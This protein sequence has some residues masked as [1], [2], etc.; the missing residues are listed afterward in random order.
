MFWGPPRAGEA[1]DLFRRGQ[2]ALA[3]DDPRE[4]IECFTRAIRLR[5]DA[6]VVY[7]YRAYAHGRLGDRISALNDLDAAI[8]L[9]PNDAQ[10]YADRAAELF[11]QQ[12]YD[13]AISDCDRALELDP[14]RV[15][16]YALRARCHAASG[17]SSRALADFAEAIA[18]DPDNAA[19]YRL[20][21]AELYGECEDYAAAMAD[22]DAALRQNPQLAAAYKLRGR[23]RQI[24]QQ[25]ADSAADF[26]AALNLQP[27]DPFALL[28]RA[29]A[30]LFLHQSH[31]ALAD[32]DAVL[33][34]RPDCAEAYAIRGQAYVQLHQFDAAIADY[35]AALQQVLKDDRITKAQKAAIAGH[36]A[37]P[38]QTPL[39]DLY[40][41][42]GHAEYLRGHYDAAV[43]DH[44][45]ALK[46]DPY[47]PYTFN[48]LA[49]IWAT[50]PDPEVR[51]GSR[52]RDCATRACEL[53]EWREP[54][55][56]DTLAAAYAECG[57]FDAAVQ[58]ETRAIELLQQQGEAAAAT[59]AEYQTRLAGYRQ[60]KPYR[61]PG[62]PP[63]A[64]AP[65]Q[66]AN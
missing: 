60:R 27:D 32:C 54:N 64:A 17:D 56:L 58:W 8:R 48:Q 20:W 24:Q 2:Q 42:R 23:L 37:I 10:T 46:C 47:N 65:G 39:V 51:N 3:N 57:E 61:I 9:Q 50:C 14:A 66:G 16:L 30:Y 13:Q 59:L 35:T 31:A 41:A 38:R 22:C 11:A 12:A 1:D 5:P 36:T 4:A 43:R 26:S 6:A 45:Q 49:W 53:S 52:A 25:W 28:G 15:G 7:R 34:R 33:A 40:N 29:A 62:P 18:R 19:Q 21:R 63:D 55:H 44:I